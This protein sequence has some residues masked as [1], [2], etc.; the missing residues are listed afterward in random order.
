MQY[1]N[2]LTLLF[3]PLTFT[4]Q[5]LPTVSPSNAQVTDPSPKE[6]VSWSK[7]CMESVVRLYYLRHGFESW[8][9]LLVTSL[10]FVAFNALRDAAT[11]ADA[12]SRSAHLSTVILCAKGLR[13]QSLCCYIAEAIFIVLRDSMQPEGLYLLKEY[14]HID[15][16]QE[17][18]QLL[19][20]RVKS[21]Y[22]VNVVSIADDPET[23]RLD[24]LIR[25]WAGLRMDDSASESELSST[26]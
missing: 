9:A 12:A 16:E 14:A 2:T 20:L 5:E 24:I 15:D 23:K 26:N 11:A 19:A 3:E 21:V 10:H 1:Y 18:K 25:A 22:P 8:D 13:E 4:D 7:A 17:R 6:I